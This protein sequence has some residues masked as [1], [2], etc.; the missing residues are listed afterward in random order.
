MTLTTGCLLYYNYIKDQ[1][2]LLAVHLS[3]QKDID[4]NLKA[5]QEREFVGQ[6][7][8]FDNNG[9]AAD[10]CNIQSMFVLMILEKIKETSLK[11]SQGSI[12]VL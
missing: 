5:I 2:R 8:Q 12:L 3:Q 9:N 4:T 6:L 1:Y 7:K 10:A 11:F